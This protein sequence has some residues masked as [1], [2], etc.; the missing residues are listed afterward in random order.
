[1]KGEKRHLTLFFD[2]RVMHG[3]SIEVTVKQYETRSTETAM[4]TWMRRQFPWDT[5]VAM[6]SEQL[7]FIQYK[8]GFYAIVDESLPTADKLLA[9]ALADIRHTNTYEEP[10]IRRSFRRLLLQYC[11]SESEL[12]MV[13]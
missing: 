3:P 12:P 10:H 7:E 9:W 5:V 6:S 2:H 8:R 13:S 4:D 11:E 1:L